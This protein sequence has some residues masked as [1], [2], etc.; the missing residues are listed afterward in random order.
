MIARL[1][2]ARKPLQVFLAQAAGLG[3]KLGVVR[4][5]LP[6]SLP[7]EARVANAFC[8]LL[9]G[10]WDGPVACEPRHA[11][12]FE[13]P[14]DSAL[15]ALRISC[16]AADQARHADAAR[17][18][19]WRGSRGDGA[20]A[21]LHHRWHGSPR[22]YW[23]RYEDAWLEEQPTLLAEWPESAVRWGIFDNTAAGGATA[24][25][26]ALAALTAP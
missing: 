17:P 12:W 21:L 15:A 25:A 7:W 16:V 13:A 6:P 4:V 18:G 23:S 3:D 20:G 11:S 1:R 26:L 14:A 8:K 2:A 5:Q 9:R 22:V 19:G 10:D 24:N